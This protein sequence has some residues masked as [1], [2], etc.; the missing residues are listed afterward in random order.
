V[1]LSQT[2]RELEQVKTFNAETA[3]T[4]QLTG[5]GTLSFIVKHGA[6]MF[7]HARRYR[8]PLSVLRIVLEGFDTVRQRTGDAVADQIIIAVAKL[9]TARMRKEDSAARVGPHHFII[10]AP[11]TSLSNALIFAKRMADEIIQAKITFQGAQIKLAAA[12]GLSVSELDPAESFA[13]LL[14]TAQRRQERALSMGSNNLVAEDEISVTQGGPGMP[15]DLERA[16]AL[17]AAGKREQLIPHLDFLARKLYPLVKL[18]DEE[19]AKRADITAQTSEAPPL[20]EMGGDPHDKTQPMS[21]L[22]EAEVKA[23]RR[24]EADEKTLKIDKHG[25]PVPEPSAP[26]KQNKKK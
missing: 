25:N 19:F 20:P 14:Q 1:K 24:R 22:Q 13:D 11:S 9:F 26:A 7:S 10:V 8:A 12:M 6:I 15:P 21:A 16:A 2:S 18:C 3:T 4:D 23:E 17:L 5:L